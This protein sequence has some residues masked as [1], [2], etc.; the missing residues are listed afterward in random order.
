[1]AINYKQFNT[2]FIEDIHGRIYFFRDLYL[3]KHGDIFE[4]AKK[5]I[6]DGD[7][8][9]NLLNKSPETQFNKTPYIIANL[10][11]LIVDVPAM[12]VSRSIG[13]IESSID[14]DEA[15]SAGAG[16]ATDETI[17]GTTDGGVNGTI[18]DV[19]QELI[20][21]IVKNSKL[22]G[23]HWG[24]L[25]QHQLDGGLVGVPW[26]DDR[27]LRIEFKAR[28][29]YFPHDDDL[30]ADLAFSRTFE[31]IQ[32]LHVYRERVYKTGE[33]EELDEISRDKG[34]L[35]NWKAPEDGLRA[36]HQLLQL[37][38]GGIITDQPLPAD[39]T[40]RY[41]KMELSDL[42][43]FYPG[44]STL[45]IRYWANE[46]TFMNPLG[47]SVLQGQENTQDEINWALTRNALVFE[48]NGK[49]RIAVNKDLAKG[50]EKSMIDAYGQ[51]ARGKF[52]SRLLE[53]F[54]MDDNGKSMEIIQIDITKIGDVQWVKDLMKLMLM[55][56]RT[57]EKAVDFYM[58][59]GGGAAQS[60]VAKF[61]D[62]FISL[63]KAEQLQEEYIDFLKGL[64]E[65][66]TWLANKR[67]PSIVIEEPE[68]G[69]REMIPVQRKEY[70]DENLSLFNANKKAISL[71]TLL[72]RIYP[73]ASDEWI[74]EEI[75]RIELEKMQTDSTSLGATGAQTFANFA[76]NRPTPGAPGA[77]ATP[78]PNGTT[79]ITPSGRP[80]GQ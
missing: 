65:D 27:G 28:D 62:L 49:P 22:K 68:I 50:L 64:I 12:L 77:A 57:S 55:E 2:E 24:N 29:T 38:A 76:D 47:V 26:D 21:Q 14:T 73:H 51:K 36:T 67:D 79:S 71:E 3:G 56:T 59:S 20:D 53:I 33:D 25:V 34:L 10:T 54:S 13:K 40:A 7:L 32:Y 9:D 43:V 16:A 11:K 48:R 6:E 19:Q 78:P 72:R 60:G 15:D 58:D 5:L 69:I 45:F 74:Q 37:G 80:P 46:K 61:Y 8:I 17:E 30:G 23:E 41:L 1:M 18:L 42:D 4:R 39:K 75:L 63:M 35:P 52:D 31:D 44:R 70:I 66:A